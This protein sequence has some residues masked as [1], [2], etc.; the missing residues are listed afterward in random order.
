MSVRDVALINAVVVDSLVEGYGAEVSLDDLAKLMSAP[1][2]EHYIAPAKNLQASGLKIDS[3][4]SNHIAG[5]VQTDKASVLVFSIPF[6][7]GWS[8]KIDGVPT[9]LFRAN[10]GMLAA[11]MP[12]GAST[13]ALDFLLPGQRMGFWLGL[14]ALA[15]LMGMSFLRLEP[16]RALI[17]RH[18]LRPTT[19]AKL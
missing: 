6:S 17:P 19:T 7:D 15:V 3:F 5:T 10:F 9:K 8:L 13:V 11:R 2:E 18:H 12:A 4:S 14:A 16:K 1:L